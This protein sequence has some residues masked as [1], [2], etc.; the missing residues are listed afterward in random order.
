MYGTTIGDTRAAATRRRAEVPA[1]HPGNSGG[2]DIEL[3]VCLNED[4]ESPIAVDAVL[5]HLLGHGDRFAGASFLSFDT[6][7]FLG[8]SKHPP[9]LIDR[10]GER[11]LFTME[12]GVLAMQFA[13]ALLTAR[14]FGAMGGIGELFA[15]ILDGQVASRQS[16]RRGHQLGQDRVSLFDGQIGFGQWVGCCVGQYIDTFC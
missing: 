10:I 16:S 5:A 15:L 13:Q 8:S 1:T 4:Y 14:I 7:V 3:F 12:L 2:Y 9:G 11:E 6:D